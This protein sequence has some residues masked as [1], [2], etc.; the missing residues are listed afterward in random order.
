MAVKASA[1]PHPHFPGRDFEGS[2]SHRSLPQ[3]SPRSSSSSLSKALSGQGVDVGVAEGTG[4]GVLEGVGV[5]VFIG[6]IVGVRVI[7]G[8]GVDVRVGVIVGVSVAV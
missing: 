6:V 5:G 4:V 8:V 2:R 7:V 1:Y 3:A